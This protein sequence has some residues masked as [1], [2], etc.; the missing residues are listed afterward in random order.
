MAIKP[1]PITRPKLVTPGNPKKTGEHI[2]PKPSYAKKKAPIKKP[3][4][5]ALTG[6]LGGFVP[7]KPNKSYGKGK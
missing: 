7:Q 1:K 5:P 4:Q 6:F 2:K 3:K